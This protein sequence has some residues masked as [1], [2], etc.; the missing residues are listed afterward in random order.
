MCC[1]PG[2]IDLARLS[3]AIVSA[4]LVA[5]GEGPG[6]CHLVFAFR[7]RLG[8]AALPAGAPRLSYEQNA[9]G[10]AEVM[11]PGQSGQPSLIPCS[12]LSECDF[13]QVT[14]GP[15]ASFQ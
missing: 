11:Q 3:Q 15:A 4:G 2:Q 9:C 14:L 7:T 8:P 5:F 10:V 12:L 1:F 13:Y 6:V